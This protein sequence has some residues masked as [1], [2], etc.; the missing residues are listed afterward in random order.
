MADPVKPSR[1]ETPDLGATGDHTFSEFG[2]AGPLFSP[3]GSRY[4]LLEEI[5]RGGMGIIY[6]AVDDSLGRE[7]A[8]K[9]LH[10]KFTPDSA[11]ARRFADEAR[12]TAQLQHP[13]IM[14]VHDVGTLADGRPF[15]AMKLIKGSTLDYLLE[16]QSDPAQERG[17][18]LAIFEQVCQVL[19]YA[20]AHDVIHRDLK[21][22]NVMIGAFGEV[23]V[24]DWGL[25]KVLTSQGGEP[26][27]DDPQATKAP[28]EVVSL[29]DT[30]GLFT[31]AGSVLGTP[32]FMPPEQAAGAV[33]EVDAQSDVF[34]LGA[35]LAVILTGQPPFVATS[36][37][38]TR[39]KAAQGKVQEC[40]ARLDGNG[41]DPELVALCK[42]CLAPDKGERPA[43]GGEVAK[44]VAQM[45]AAAE[46]R[47]RR[48]EL[49][50]V[51]LE[52]EKAVA[53]ANDAERR[54]TQATCGRG[55]GGAGAGGR[56]GPLGDAGGAAAGQCGIGRGAGQG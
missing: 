44:A 33:D 48:A 26:P 14:P 52:G 35:I 51:R 25:A 31:Q 17:R 23:Q 10:E 6:R 28:T 45:R 11:M 13:A 56:R 29:R 19:A 30:D 20:H 43:D 39:V 54:Q 46:E 18:Y 32:A 9:V 34:G 22:A 36:A 55:G 12:I 42:R 21:P 7:V 53:E 3:G 47:A 1:E 5:A 4:R 37:E 50:R 41:A 38:T 15:L 40:F 49:E 27:G 24:M 16:A 2:R 8:V